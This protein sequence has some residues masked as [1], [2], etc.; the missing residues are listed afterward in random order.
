MNVIFSK[1]IGT[2]CNLEWCQQSQSPQLSLVPA[3]LREVLLT[4]E[5]LSIFWETLI[6]L[7]KSILVF[8][9][10]YEMVH[11]PHQPCVLHYCMQ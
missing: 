5:V 9:W 7:P 8:L 1:E 10:I 2:N 6:I 11:L 4:C 3:G